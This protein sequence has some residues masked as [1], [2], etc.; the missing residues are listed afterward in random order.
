M[1]I[2]R[3]IFFVILDIVLFLRK[4]FKK[5]YHLSQFFYF[6]FTSKKLSSNLVA[7]M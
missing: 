6:I 2:A 5:Y 1:F 4:V 7:R 3:N